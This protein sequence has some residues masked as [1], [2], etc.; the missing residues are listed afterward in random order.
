VNSIQLYKDET[1]AWRIISMIWDNERDG[2][3]VA[4]F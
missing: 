2:V 3:K 4:P 1:G